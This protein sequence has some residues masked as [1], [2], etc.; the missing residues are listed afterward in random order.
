LF[1][2]WRA[3][4]IGLDLTI[5]ACATLNLT[6]FLHRLAGRREGAASHRVAAL[7]LAL[8]SLGAIVESIFILAYLAVPGPPIASLSWTMARVIPLAGTALV[9]AII[10]RRLANP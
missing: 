10:I 3:T 2:P 6:Y 1:T 8:V 5:A 9:S 7:A 4:A